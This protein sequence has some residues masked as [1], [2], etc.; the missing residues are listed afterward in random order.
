MSIFSWSLLCVV[1]VS[2]SAFIM[3]RQNKTNPNTQPTHHLDPNHMDQVA[4]DSKHARRIFEEL[5]RGNNSIDMD[6]LKR[7]LNSSD[8]NGDGQVTSDEF[9]LTWYQNDI[10][11]LVNAV[12]FFFKIDVNKD[13]RIT[14]DGDLKYIFDMFDRNGDGV[15]D[16]AEF[17][18]QWVKLTS[19]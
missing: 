5:A 16:E 19:L 18:V 7:F 14:A 2:T 17:V 3:P 12:P 11:S 8:I 9:L 1:T 6:D 15:V 10:G 4:V 13:D